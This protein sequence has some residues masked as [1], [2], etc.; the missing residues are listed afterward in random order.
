MR[1]NPTAAMLAGLIAI[2]LTGCGGGYVTI[3]PDPG[4]VASQNPNSPKVREL[5][6]KSLA[7]VLEQAQLETPVTL[8]MPETTTKLTHAAV[9]SKVEGA[10]G[11]EEK[12]PADA[13]TLEVTGVRIRANEAAVDI[14]RP[15]SQ[16][17]SVKQLVT[18]SAKWDLFTGWNIQRVRVW[19]GVES[20]D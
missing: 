3:P 20:P 16:G 6:A 18:A 12:A 19:R 1:R 7:A 4:D 11:P 10:L 13:P 5:M 8:A 14:L 15:R 9:A 17:E 2:T